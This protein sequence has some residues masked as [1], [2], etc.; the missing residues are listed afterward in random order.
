MKINHATLKLASNSSSKRSTL[1]NRKNT[2]TNSY[3]GGMN[4][5]LNS[6]SGLNVTKITQVRVSL[7][8]S[9]FS[10]AGSQ[11]TECWFIKT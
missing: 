6:L 5:I 9:I 4:C 3:G 7:K 10:S 1:L 8:S 2:L 11:Q